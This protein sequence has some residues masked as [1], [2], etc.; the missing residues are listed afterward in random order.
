MPPAPRQK[1]L[2]RPTRYSSA[3]LI[4]AR[5]ASLRFGLKTIFAIGSL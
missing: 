1:M 2:E 3:F 5:L 4:V